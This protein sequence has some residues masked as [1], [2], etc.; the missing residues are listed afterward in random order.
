MLVLSLCKFNDYFAML[1]I[2]NTIEFRKWK[3]QTGIFERKST[4]KKKLSLDIIKM[5]QDLGG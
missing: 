1:L 3:V 2:I 5:K 4:E